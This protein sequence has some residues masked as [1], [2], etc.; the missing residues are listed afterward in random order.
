M[1]RAGVSGGMVFMQGVKKCVIS[2]KQL[3]KGDKCSL[4]N[5]GFLWLLLR[6]SLNWTVRAPS[7]VPSCLQGSK[8]FQQLGN[9]YSE[10][11]KWTPA[12]I[13]TRQTDS[14]TSQI[15]D[16]ISVLWSC[17]WSG[18]AGRYLICQKTPCTSNIFWNDVASWDIALGW[19]LGLSQ[20]LQPL[21]WWQ[22]QPALPVSFQG[23]Q[24]AHL[25]G[26][27]SRAHLDVISCNLQCIK[28]PWLQLCLTIL[29]HMGPCGLPGYLS[30]LHSLFWHTVNGK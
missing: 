16:R 20:L 2:E 7:P 24:T 18:A 8:I 5:M 1:S 9:K 27:H 22:T 28:F 29:T 13:H 14:G 11:L 17:P 4:A 19:S 23:L 21:R 15:Q 6:T 26:F 3:R 12:S 25:N 10:L 30:P